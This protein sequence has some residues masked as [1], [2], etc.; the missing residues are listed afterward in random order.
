MPYDLFLFDADETLF[1]FRASEKLA[2]AGA[3]AEFGVT[4]DLE[5]ISATYRAESERLWQQLEQGTTTK[6]FLKTERFRRTCAAH[7]LA[8]DAAVLG[9]RY[10][11]LLPENVVLIDHAEEILAHLSAQGEV[12]ILT[13]G[14][15]RVQT[16]RLE[17]SGLKKYV[18]FMAVSEACGCAKPDPRFFECGVR[19][20]RKFTRE[21]AVMIGDRLEADILGGHRFGVDT[22][23][24]NPLARAHAGEVHPT[25]EIRHL[26][27][28][29][30]IL[31]PE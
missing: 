4:G 23:W 6:D 14:I 10:L 16:R 2:L 30:K 25:H 15:E 21:S 20:A 12:G 11:D 17:K 26:S 1:D 18:S 31:T 29:R 24:F 28:L 3:F 22:V 27:E 5:A 8:I 19:L 7:G 9:E 13:N